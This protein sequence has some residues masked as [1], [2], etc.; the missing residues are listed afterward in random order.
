MSRRRAFE[1]CRF[2]G[3]GEALR[4]LYGTERQDAFMR[5]PRCDRATAR[6]ARIASLRIHND[7]SRSDARSDALARLLLSAAEAGD[8]RRFDRDIT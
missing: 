1:D 6:R 7:E 3:A 4:H 8:L 2:D 5:L